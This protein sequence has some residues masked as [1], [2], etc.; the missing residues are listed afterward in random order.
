[1]L[2]ARQLA[3]DLLVGRIEVGRHLEFVMAKNLANLRFAIK[4]SSGHVSSIWRLW[5]TRQGDV[6]LATRAIAHIEKYS[7]HKSGICR[8]AFTNEH[9]TPITMTD[10]AMFKWM[11]LPTPPPSEGKAARVAWLAFPTD[12][13]SR[14]SESHVDGV[15]W[16][17]AAPAGGATYIDLA[18]TAESEESIRK[19]FGQRRERTL[20]MYSKLPDDE[21]VFVN[22]YHAD[23]ENKDLSVPGSGKVADIVFSAIDPHNTGRPIRIRLGPAPSDGDAVVLR[24][25]GGYP[26]PNTPNP[27]LQGT[28]ES[29]R[30]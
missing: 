27:A 4:S 30:P 17:A 1:V 28:P 7:F 18:F 29:G 19:A 10:R 14:E 15:T 26:V 3:A 20:R 5:V 8:S 25:L 23:W 13:L 9:G 6:Y 16:L 21:A 22:Y 24:E 2:A 11:R 12:Y